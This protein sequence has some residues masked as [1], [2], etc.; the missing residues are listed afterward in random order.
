MNCPVNLLRARPSRQDSGKRLRDSVDAVLDRVPI[1][2]YL[3]LNWPMSFL[4]PTTLNL[5]SSK[6]SLSCILKAEKSI[7]EQPVPPRNAT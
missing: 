2:C 4:V 3:E 6:S 7:V 1:V 5:H